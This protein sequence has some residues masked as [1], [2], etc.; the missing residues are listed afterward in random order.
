MASLSV[1]PTP[2]LPSM[3][4]SVMPSSSW[5]AS[6]VNPRDCTKPWHPT[7]PLGSTI[8]PALPPWRPTSYLCVSLSQLSMDSN[9][10][11]LYIPGYGATHSSM[12]GPT[13]SHTIKESYQ[14]SIAPQ[15]WGLMIP[16]PL[17]ARMLTVNWHDL[18]WYFLFL[19]AFHVAMSK[20][21][22]LRFI[23]QVHHAPCWARLWQ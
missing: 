23:C 18:V 16:F 10:C 11:C 3:C 7:L 12:A 13:R 14:L 2:A 20:Y 1:Y 4:E 17:H 22:L 19:S 15:R 5:N 9:F 8:H 6:Q 21:T